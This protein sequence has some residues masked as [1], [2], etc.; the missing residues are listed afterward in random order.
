MRDV[1]ESHGYTPAPEGAKDPVRGQM[2]YVPLKKTSRAPE[3]PTYHDG[4][5]FRQIYYEIQD[6]LK[7]MPEDK[8]QIGEVN[9]YSAHGETIT[10]ATPIDEYLS[11]IRRLKDVTKFESWGNWIQERF[12]SH[13]RRYYHYDQANSVYAR[14][15]QALA[16][17]INE[18]VAKRDGKKAV[19]NTAFIKD[20]KEWVL[21]YT[22]TMN[23]FKRAESGVTLAPFEQ[24]WQTIAMKHLIREGIN[25]GHDRIFLQTGDVHGIRWS[26]GT[27]VPEVGWKKLTP[28]DDKTLDMFTG[29]PHPNKDG[30]IVLTTQGRNEPVSVKP[31]KVHAIV[32]REVAKII[33]DSVE[34]EGN[35]TENDVDNPIFWAT[36]DRL[37]GGREVY[38][39]ITVFQLNKFLKPFK[40]KVKLGVFKPENGNVEMYA[41]KGAMVRQ[42]EYKSELAEAFVDHMS[43]R[44]I[45]SAWQNRDNAEAIAKQM[46]SARTVGD[47]FWAV[48]KKP[49]GELFEFSY[50]PTQEQADQKFQEAK[51]KEMANA[52]GIEVWEIEFTDELKQGAETG[53]PLF[54]KKRNHTRADEG[55]FQIIDG[56]TGKQVGKN[57]QGKNARKRARTRIDK[58]DNEYGA[59]R[60]RLRDAETKQV[61]FS[62]APAGRTS[63]RRSTP[64]RRRSGHRSHVQSRSSRP[65][66]GASSASAIRAGRSSRRWWISSLGSST[67]SA[68]RTA[69]TCLLRS[70]ATSRRTSPPR[71]TR[72]CM[73]S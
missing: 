19:N 35:V 48:R 73:R 27:Q 67:R 16:P 7:K 11:S 12:D 49:D 47:P 69:T 6:R 60:Y 68:K 39:S 31:G 71:V 55:P 20:L 61:R 46:G 37:S 44:E 34:T 17:H 8:P 72:R 15:F 50:V 57:Y 45:E 64:W 41:D 32:G 3:G 62:S 4:T 29:K 51:T 28:Q 65:S 13:Q 10:E 25:R 9:P 53:F 1:F 22:E 36:S 23:K 30:L 26:G 18:F 24:V 52:A 33:L 56:Q 5:T 59:Y 21:E 66:T 2:P 70:Q 42:L 43:E 63:I 54:S 38:N 14:T 40:A 58:L